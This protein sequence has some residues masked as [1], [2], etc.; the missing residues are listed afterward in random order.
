[1][2][3]IWN[4]PEWLEKEVRD[5]RVRER[6]CVFNLLTGQGRLKGTRSVVKNPI[7]IRA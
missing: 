7:V 1:M 4:I 6:G 5:P 2:P 3:N